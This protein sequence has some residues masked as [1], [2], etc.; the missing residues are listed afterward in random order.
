MIW[1]KS[2]APILVDHDAPLHFVV[3][4]PS[5]RPARLEPYMGMAG[6]AKITPEDGAGFVHLHPSGTVSLAAPETFA[7]GQPG[8]TGRGLLPARLTGKG[9]VGRRQGPGA[10]P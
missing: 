1:D 4:D 6:H 9:K 3:T 8:G 10:G 7:L 5:G 2:P